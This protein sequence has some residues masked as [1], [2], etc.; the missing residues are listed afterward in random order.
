MNITIHNTNQNKIAEV[1]SYKIIIKEKNLAPDFF[2][3]KSGLAGDILQKC[4]N[5]RMKLA[6][7]GKFD[8]YNS[9]SLKAFIIEC[10]RGNQFFFVPDIPKAKEMLVKA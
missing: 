10:N 1:I 3:L 5:Y 2:N 9:K 4:V 6:I 7:V 8:K